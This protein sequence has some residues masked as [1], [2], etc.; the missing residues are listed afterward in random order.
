MKFKTN[1]KH[2]ISAIIKD[3]SY[4]FLIMTVTQ[5]TNMNLKWYFS[6]YTTPESIVINVYRDGRCASQLT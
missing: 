1:L 2:S 3:K 4:V 5:A 6:K